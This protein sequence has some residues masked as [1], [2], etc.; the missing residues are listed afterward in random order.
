MVTEVHKG[1]ETYYKCGVCGSVYREKEIAEK[2]QN[3]C[4][5]HEGSCNI[6]YIQYAVQLDDK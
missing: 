4:E 3:W 5:T 2:C 6:E 1:T